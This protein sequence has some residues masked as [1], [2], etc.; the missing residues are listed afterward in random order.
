MSRSKYIHP[1]VVVG[2]PIP[3]IEPRVD[4]EVLGS[5]M[6][7]LRYSYWYL[8]IFMVCSMS[9]GLLNGQ[10]WM[11]ISVCAA[12]LIIWVVPSLKNRDALKRY[13]Q[14]QSCIPVAVDMRYRLMS[15]AVALSFSLPLM[16]SFGLSLAVTMIGFYAIMFGLFLISM[17]FKA[18]EPGQ[19]SCRACSYAL[20]GLVLPC[21]CPEC[22]RVI[23]ELVD[24]TDRPRV[25]QPWFGWVGVGLC[26]MGIVLGCSV[27]LGGDVMYR[28]MPRSVLLRLAANDR[29]AF[30]EI[31]SMKLDE[32]EQSR[33][34]DSVISM[35][36]TT[37]II[38]GSSY[39]QKEWLLGSYL[40]E[41]M[42]DEQVGRLL[43]PY[44]AADLIVLD[45]PDSARVGE[46]IE[47]K[48]LG[49]RHRM[50]GDEMMPMMYFRGYEIQRDGESQGQTDGLHAGSVFARTL[51]LITPRGREIDWHRDAD[52]NVDGRGSPEFMYLAQEPGVLV[53]R[54]RVVVALIRGRTIRTV[55]DWEKP[56]AEAFEKVPV[57][58]R[59]IDL[60][61]RVL[62]TE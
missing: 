12:G 56:I 51:Y 62:V 31:T 15:L 37:G 47:I 26:L 34:I 6:K 35:K 2:E 41:A 52:G 4:V 43:E 60:E 39:E 49:Q 24:T 54:C 20:T 16:I 23:G 21:Q 44:L 33:L 42:N 46:P 7:M 8:P 48:L 28:R 40:S 18:R 1:D 50:P 58:Y 45:V 36:S 22:G 29:N 9:L 30:E 32:T 61:H 14:D 57:W 17:V 55:I 53:V 38:S 19:I 5:A 3:E 27:W 59:V 11:M 13:Q 25:S 10:L